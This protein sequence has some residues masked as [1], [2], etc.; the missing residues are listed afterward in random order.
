MNRVAA[1]PDM[2]WRAA[3]IVMRGLEPHIQGLAEPGS[4]PQRLV[5]QARWLRDR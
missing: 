4:P 1:G 2:F 5:L 3:M